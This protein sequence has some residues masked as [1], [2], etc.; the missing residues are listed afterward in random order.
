LSASLEEGYGTAAAVLWRSS[1]VKINIRDDSSLRQAAR[2]FPTIKEIRV[3]S[4]GGRSFP[5]AGQADWV[6][7][8]WWLPEPGAPLRA[9][10][11]PELNS[12]KRP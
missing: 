9:A 12:S 2:L 1:H 8:T 5:L 10:P 11:G 7:V 4:S 3:Q 6:A